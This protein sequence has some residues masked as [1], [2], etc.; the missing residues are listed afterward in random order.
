MLPSEP[1]RR[2]PA[3]GAKN[4][5]QN[6]GADVKHGGGS[7]STSL[8]YIHWLWRRAAYW[9]RHL[10]ATRSYI[11]NW[12][13]WR[14]LSSTLAATHSP[15]PTSMTSGSSS[16]LTPKLVAKGRRPMLP[17]LHQPSKSRQESQTS[18]IN[19]ERAPL[20]AL[21]VLKI[22]PKMGPLATALRILL[23]D[24]PLLLLTWGAGLR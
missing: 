15:L 18:Q 17:R 11:Q 13:A 14:D 10:P 21:K 9:L 12:T 24:F 16:A 2:C 3:V 22:M 20:G 4:H 8:D 5:C 6:Y 7:H 19:T 23:Q 1:L